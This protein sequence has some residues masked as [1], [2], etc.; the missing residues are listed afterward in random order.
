[1]KTKRKETPVR[2]QYLALNGDDELLFWLGVRVGPCGEISFEH[3]G[4]IA[5]AAAIHHIFS[6]GT[7]PDYWTNLIGL[8]IHA[9][10]AVHSGM[11]DEPKSIRVLCLL[12]KW[13]K[14]CASPKG[15]LGRPEWNTY[16]L[17]KAYGKPLLGLI[18][19]VEF[20]D[21]FL[22]CGRRDLARLVRD[23]ET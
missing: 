12:A 19:S 2:D 18:D 17:R 6:F 1:M 16:L 3:H 9:H 7:R 13:K 5:P 20:E 10:D 22:E 21:D 14:H 23:I 4:Q 15:E 8:N 11:R